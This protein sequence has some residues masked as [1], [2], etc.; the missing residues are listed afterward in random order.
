[1]ENVLARDLMTTPQ[2]VRADTPLR[3]VARRLVAEKL[4]GVCVVDPTGKLEGVLTAMDLLFQE[5]QVKGPKIFWLIDSPVIF[6][7]DRYEH[8]L[9]KKIGSTVRD[10]MTAR[11]TSVKEDARIDEIATLMVDNGFSVLPVVRDGVPIGMIT[12]WD[13]LRRVLEDDPTR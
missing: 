10:V 12:K 13:V 7:Q 9:Q 3:D 8:D 2:S 11:P 1:M 5:K 6:G 4:D